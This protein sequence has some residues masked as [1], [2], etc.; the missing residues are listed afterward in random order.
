MV[1][2]TPKLD[3]RKAMMGARG[4]I[5]EGLDMAA[6][7]G[8]KTPATLGRFGRRAWDEALASLV[9]NTNLALIDLRALEMMCR[10]YEVW[11]IAERTIKD[12]E[13]ADA[14]SGEYTVTP[15]GHRQMSAERITANRAMREF[16]RIAP[17]FGATPV[18]RIR[19]TGTAQGDLF[20]W[21]AP[22]PAPTPDE[23]GPPDPT[24]PYG[25]VGVLPN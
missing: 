1:G 7:A 23:G 3:G 5:A 4:L 25:V 9:P 17:L 2:R 11:A 22:A 19:V 16:M 21:A 14:G 13:R 15:N 12:H 6:I 10:Q 24:D 18:G 8:L 20:D